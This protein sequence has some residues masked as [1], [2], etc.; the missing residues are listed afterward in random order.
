MTNKTIDLYEELKRLLEYSGKHVEGV[1]LTADG[2][3]ASVNM[4]N[5]TVNVFM[6]KQTPK[7]RSWEPMSN[8]EFEQY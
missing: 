8:A 1:S 3:F 5:E 2:V 4:G 7:A 6:T